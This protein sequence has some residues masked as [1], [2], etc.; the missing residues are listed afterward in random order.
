MP[1][2]TDSITGEVVP[3]ALETV[4]ARK[5]SA[6]ERVEAFLVE[7]RKMRGL[8]PSQVIA[9]NGKGFSEADL[10]ELVAL[11]C[12][13]VG[14]ETPSDLHLFDRWGDVWISVDGGDSWGYG[15]PPIEG[16]PLWDLERV[17]RV[18]GIDAHATVRA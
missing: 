2:I 10:E 17:A 4:L 6:V 3:G 14:D 1:E 13:I 8:D 9:A 11:A 16:R 12:R 5:P 15:H 18:F 7:R